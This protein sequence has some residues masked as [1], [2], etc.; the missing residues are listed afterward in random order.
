MKN[1]KNKKT[2]ILVASFVIVAIISFSVGSKFSK[3]KNVRDMQGGKFSQQMGM[4]GSGFG[5]GMINGEIL[6]KDDTSITLKLKDGGSK[7]VFYTDK[8]TVAKT[9]DGILSDLVVGKQ[10]NVI[11]TTNPDGS[12]SA[13][14]VQIRTVPI[15]I[16]AQ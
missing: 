6:S 12:V 9:L 2:I 3:P 16:P 8:T 11:G 15:P 4:K 1:L 14:S 13:Q 7:I 5:G 10:I